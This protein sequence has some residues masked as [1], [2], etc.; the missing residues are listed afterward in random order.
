MLSDL[1]YTSKIFSE[2]VY[3]MELLLCRNVSYKY[4]TK[5]FIFFLL[6][7]KVTTIARQSF[8]TGPYKREKKGKKKGFIRN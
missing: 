5:I 8:N 1:V 3:M 6:K 7:S 2:T 4:N